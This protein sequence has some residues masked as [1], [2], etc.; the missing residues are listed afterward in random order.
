MGTWSAAMMVGGC[1]TGCGS[2]SS[3]CCRRRR[4]TRWVVT[5]RGCPIAARWTRSCWCCGPGCSGTRWTRPGSAPRVSAHRRFQEWERAGVFAEI[6]RQ[7]LLEY[8]EVVGIDWAWLAADGAMT[9]APLGGPKTGPN[10]TDRAKRGRSVRFSC[11]ARR[12]PDRARARRREPQRSQAARADARLDPDRA[13]RADPEQPAGPLP[14]QGLRQPDSARARRSQHG[15]T[16]HIRTRGEEIADKVRTPGWRARRWVVEAC[17][18]WLNRNRGDPDPL[19]QEG[20]EPPRPAAS[21]QRPDRIQE[22]P[23]RHTRRPQPG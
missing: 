3:R 2:G 11:E 6:W 20:R 12:G 1:R 4:F 10:P 23:R 19:V 15:F 7:G 22:S 9:K 8:D 18:S 17:H 13:A 14:R 16:P 21:R 5:R